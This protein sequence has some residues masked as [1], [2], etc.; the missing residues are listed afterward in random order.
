V[1][2]GKGSGNIK[3]LN[4]LKAIIEEAAKIPAPDVDPEAYVDYGSEKRFVVKT[5]RGECAA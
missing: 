1:L 3:D 2:A 5:S 4:A